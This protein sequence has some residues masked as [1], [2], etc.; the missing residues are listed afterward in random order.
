MKIIFEKNLKAKVL[1]V[2]T[3]KNNFNRLTVK[4]LTDYE[5]IIKELD[6]VF[7]GVGTFNKDFIYDFFIQS[8]KDPKYG[9]QF[10]ILSYTVSYQN[11]S[12]GIINFLKSK[13]FENI[14]EKTAKK[15][16]DVLGEDA[17]EKI[18]KDKDLLIKP[19]LSLPVSKAKTIY[20]NLLILKNQQDFKERLSLVK[21]N[22]T[23][24]QIN[25]I[26]EKYKDESVEIINTNPYILIKDIDGISFKKADNIALQFG[27]SLDSEYRVKACINFLLNEYCEQ[28][29]NSYLTF[30]QLFNQLENYLNI[31]INLK[32]FNNCIEELI[33]EKSVFYDK[34]VEYYYSYQNYMNEYNIFKDIKRLNKKD[35]KIDIEKL[36]ILF[37][38]L[39][40]ESIK[41]S[42]DQ[43][44]A[45]FNSLINNFSIIT[46]GP[47][48]GKTT[49]IKGIIKIYCKYYNLNTKEEKHAHIK[50]MSPTGRAAK[51]MEEVLDHQALTIHKSLEYFEA[52]FR[53]NRKNQLYA[54][55]II[56]DE[57]SMIDQFICAKLLESIKNNTKVIFVG[58]VNQLPSVGLGQVL[59]D[60]ID[61]KTVCVSLLNYIHRQKQDSNILDLAYSINNKNINLYEINNY[62][63]NSKFENDV[64]YRLIN[65]IE[66]LKITLEKIY[67]F[68]K[69]NKYNIYDDF[70]IIISQKD[71][72]FGTNNINKI[73]SDI[74]NKDNSE[75]II[76]GEKTFFLYDK[77]IQ[78]KNMYEHNVM[79]GDIG[80][81]KQIYSNKIV[82]YF[83][84]NEI[85]VEYDNTN[86]DQIQLAYA[87]TVHKSQ[88]SEYK[89]LVFLLHRSQQ[90]MINKN[91]LYTAVTRAKEKLIILGD[92]GLLER[93]N[94][95]SK[96]KQTSLKKL[97]TTD[98]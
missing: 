78:T 71:G 8:Y 61:S 17:I 36:N 18:M 20:N 91:L 83:P 29:G 97:L 85:L 89:L 46:G 75:F 88:G 82:V 72:D 87:I 12:N 94:I 13:K 79:N 47:G 2:N 59:K 7:K 81:V 10:K 77:V 98:S 76:F 73:I 86:I 65:N 37:N 57:A 25:K 27:I 38:E 69:D 14:G 45:V 19:P 6:Y 26:I 62:I 23:E 70:Q 4:I 31:N 32:K 42:N 1:K 35:E 9:I 40:N 64:L 84:Q 3:Y 11:T 16:I 30:E 15:I 92:Y 55:L 74:I 41:Y 48:T 52:G 33:I 28:E 51:R 53:I 21:L 5:G 50:L 93:S 39:E 56:V 80:F 63:R 22:L 90:F 96:E 67:K 49:I 24:L 58:D 34:D 54:N 66:H 60:I 68:I 95:E 44:N 43:K